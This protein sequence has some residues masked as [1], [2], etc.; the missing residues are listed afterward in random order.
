MCRGEA[1]KNKSHLIKHICR[2][3]SPLLAP[4][5]FIVPQ[6]LV[7]P[8]WVEMPARTVHQVNIIHGETAKFI[9]ANTRKDALIAMH[10]VGRVKF[11]TN[12]RI[13]D[14]AGLVSN[15]PAQMVWEKRATLKTSLIA[16]DSIAAELITKH[17]PEMV[18]VSAVW[19]PY[20]SANHDALKPIWR[21]TQLVD[22]VECIPEMYVYEPTPDA[23]STIMY[24]TKNGFRPDKQWVVRTFVPEVFTILQNTAAIPEQ[25]REQYIARVRK[26]SEQTHPYF[27][28][29]LAN[30]I[31]D[32]ISWKEFD[33]AIAVT[34]FAKI[35]Y[36]R[37]R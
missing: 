13:L 17:N 12:R 32:L 2:N 35:L 7:L 24:F 3:A 23:D 26:D 36:H 14:L 11:D 1:F 33:S 29:A 34:E 31:A 10:D 8:I 28:I 6:I 20:L 21:T 25:E 9:S 5:I 30:I 37:E 4:L 27:R 15:E 18:A 16:F 22:A 19:F